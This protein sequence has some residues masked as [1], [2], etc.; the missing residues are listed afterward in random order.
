MPPDLVNAHE[1]LDKAVLVAYGLQPSS[2]DA[3]VLA[4]LFTRFGELSA[5][6]GLGGAVASKG[7]KRK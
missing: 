5:P 6:L 1:G 3:E 4:Q 2:S 7:R